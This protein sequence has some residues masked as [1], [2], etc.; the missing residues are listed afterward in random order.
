MRPD[1][2][3]GRAELLEDQAARDSY[4]GKT[5]LVSGAGGSIGTELCRQVLACGPAGLILYELNEFALYTVELAL[6]DPAARAGIPLV[7]V[8]GSVAEGDQVARVLATHRVEVILH[9]AAY[10]HVPLVEANPLAGIANNG[11]GTQVF[12]HAAAAAGV[13]RFVLISS[14][15]AV[16]PANVMGA[17]KRLAELVVQDLARR[18]PGT[19]FSI[20]RFGNVF[21]SSGSVVQRFRAQIAAGGPVTVTHPRMSRYFMTIEEAVRL[22]LHAGALAQGGE[23]FVLDMGR[24][25]PI[26]ALARQMIAAAGRAETEIVFT[27]P[28]PGEKL[29]EALSESGV[30]EKTGHP[31]ILTAREAPLS[32]TETALLLR[33]LQREVAAGN[34]QAACHALQFH[35]VGTPGGAAAPAEGGVA[36]DRGSV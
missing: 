25:V 11:L 20:V 12:A 33:K 26:L 6:R 14:D 27:G 17:S 7:A 2:F 15:K 36:Q 10:K 16:R 31:K 24:P 9:A 19:V 30:L 21:G 28:R 29:T 3:L 5:V 23:V 8:L 35:G 32:D 18:S 4:A 34:A 22:V 1:Q 13:A